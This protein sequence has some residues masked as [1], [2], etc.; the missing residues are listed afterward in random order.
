[1]T[2]GSRSRSVTAFFRSGDTGDLNAEDAEAHRDRNLA[3][4]LAVATPGLLAV[5]GQRHWE[6]SY[7]WSDQIFYGSPEEVRRKMKSYIARMEAEEAL[8]EAA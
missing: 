1:L 6:I 7:P 3:Q 8:D 4:G 5:T 2:S